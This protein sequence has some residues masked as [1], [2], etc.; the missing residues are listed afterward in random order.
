MSRYWDLLKLKSL[1]GAPERPNEAATVSATDAPDPQPA[2]AP[3]AEPAILPA[4][5]PVAAPRA[6]V[7][8]EIPPGT[9]NGGLTGRNA[10]HR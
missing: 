2:T 10:D 5:E 3:S 6:E 4:E 7:Q 1:L 9:A 8:A